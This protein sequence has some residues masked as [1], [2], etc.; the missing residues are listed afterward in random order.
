MS[1]DNENIENNV[2]RLDQTFF[3]RMKKDII[4][5]LKSTAVHIGVHI[6]KKCY[7][8]YIRKQTKSSLKEGHMDVKPK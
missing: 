5:N 7:K 4:F 8:V 6:N 1:G 2:E 3:K